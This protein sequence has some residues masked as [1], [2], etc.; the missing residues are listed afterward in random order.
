LLNYAAIDYKISSIYSGKPIFELQLNSSAKEA[1]E[2][3]AKNRSS[4]T[5][6]FSILPDLSPNFNI[7]IQA[8]LD[9]LQNLLKN[10]KT[11]KL[12]IQLFQQVNHF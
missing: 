7:P 12:I 4:D 3:Y 2:I 5:I 6:I 11:K 10:L 1:F 9:Y 8:H